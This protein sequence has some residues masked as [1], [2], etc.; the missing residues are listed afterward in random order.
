MVLK[1]W[2]ASTATAGMVAGAS[3]GVGASAAPAFELPVGASASSTA[4]LLAGEPS[5]WAGVP[6]R[7]VGLNRTPPLYEGDPP[8]DGA[9]PALRVA[10]VRTSGSLL[11]RLR[12]H[13]P[14]DSSPKP[15]GAVPDA[16]APEIYQK[17]SADIERFADAACVMIPQTPGAH[18]AMPSLMMGEAGQPVTLYY[19]N[20][21]RGFERLDAA[22][23]GT[24]TRSGATFPGEVR[25]TAE[26]WE[27]VFQLPDQPG[28]TPLS[29][30]V[31]DGDQAQRD[32]LKFF[33][34]WH[35]L[36]P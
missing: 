11:V 19:W 13:D 4:S 28:A 16:G 27:A 7:A 29:F 21:V 5:A 1:R 18:A 14:T 8:D 2:I 26:G 34:V 32:G 35:E 36:A 9:R 3:V 24:T 20:N 33:S 25:R 17:H 30:A 12:W 31:W 23:R 22:G 6:E 15:A 10:C